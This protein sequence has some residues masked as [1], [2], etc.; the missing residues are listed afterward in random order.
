MLKKPATKRS[1]IVAA[2][3]SVIATAALTFGGLQALAPTDTMG[4]E[5][6]TANF[7]SQF[8]SEE[9]PLEVVGQWAR[10]SYRANASTD[11]VANSPYRTTPQNTVTNQFACA[12]GGSGDMCGQT[13]FRSGAKISQPSQTQIEWTP[14]VRLRILAT[15]Y[16]QIDQNIVTEAQC[17]P[18][19]DVQGKEPQWGFKYG[20]DGY[21]RNNGF[22]H[23][24]HDTSNLRVNSG[25]IFNPLKSGE[26]F[27]DIQRMANGADTFME[28]KVTPTWGQD[29]SRK[30]A[31]SELTIEAQGFY[32]DNRSQVGPKWTYKFS[33]RCGLN[34][35]N[36][37]GST[38][39]STSTVSNGAVPPEVDIDF[40]AEVPSTVPSEEATFALESATG[41]GR[42]EEVQHLG[43]AFLV[44]A[45]RE[46]SGEDREHISTVLSQAAL[47][48]EE[49]GMING[50][51]WI[52]R[53]AN[54]LPV[55]T[56][57]LPGGGY[58][59]V[60]PDV[61]LLVPEIPQEELP[62]TDAEQTAPTTGAD[63][64]AT[65]EVE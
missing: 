28:I 26:T 24:R 8:R 58:A 17:S 62:A 43:A 2:T 33:S 51:A 38:G 1:R 46:L 48:F 50:L 4:A 29:E 44:E 27:T 40:G 61:E 41:Y 60:T 25:R 16:F 65:E 49:D 56:L 21:V 3:G 36:N 30:E 39:P 11:T 54:G 59:R 32:Q 22:T 19:G 15:A 20:N 10:A 9:K 45:T 23:L 37:T 13:G 55:V 14:S 12:H 53:Q 35:N 5:V 57:E 63:E 52:R 64:I 31:W 34:M 6:R 18:N 47:A 7:T 42:P